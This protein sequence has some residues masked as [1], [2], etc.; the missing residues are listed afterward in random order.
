M[1]EFLILTETVQDVREG[2]DR[3]EDDRRVVGKSPH[4]SFVPQSAADLAKEKVS[5]QDKQKRRKRAAL[6]D[7]TEGRKGK[8]FP[9]TNKLSVIFVE[10]LEDSDPFWRK[11]HSLKCHP[12]NPD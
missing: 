12:E 9:P 7:T 6:S 2:V 8:L 4:N 3:F 11:T 1:R 10:D 5:N